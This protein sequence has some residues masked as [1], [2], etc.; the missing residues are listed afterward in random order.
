[1]T[2]GAHTFQRELVGESLLKLKV[3]TQAMVLSF[4]NGFR[5]TALAMAL[6]VFLVV[7]LKRP[8]QGGA[9]PVDAH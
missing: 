2:V 4:E 3:T 1:M 5:W 9:A 7:L 6:G 8:P